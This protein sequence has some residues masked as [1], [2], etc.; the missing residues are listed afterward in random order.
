MDGM[1]LVVTGAGRGIGRDI[2]LLAGRQGAR[3]VVNDLGASAEGA[4]ADTTPAE[5][6]VE[7]I[8]SSGGSAVLNTDTVA[9]EEG[10]A[11]IVAACLRA[12]GR[13][14][15]VVNN[16]GI[17]R[18]RIFHHMTAEDFEA[19]V[20]VHLFGTFHVSR[21]AAAHFRSQGGGTFVHLT[22]TSGLIGN[23]GQANYAAAKMGVVGLSKAIALDMQRY[24]V[25]SNCIAP[26]AWTRLAATIPGDDGGAESVRVQRMRAMTA[27][28]VAPL[29]IFLACPLSAGVTGQVFGVR[30]NEVFL[31]SQPRPIRS[32]HHAAGW[33]VGSLR[34]VMLPALRPS[35]V[36]LDRSA[37]VFS[38]DPI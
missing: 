25:R 7:E 34:D 2:A 21:A 37:D 29:A 14:D 27:E 22:S 19:V 31:F 15:A 8:R 20:R 13:V 38:W 35:F 18:D 23:L 11:A 33:D 5:S 16:A 28:K 26:F 32:V 1:S 4:G 36:P 6:V 3:V 17:L 30:Q 24:D 9:T 12:F 10:A